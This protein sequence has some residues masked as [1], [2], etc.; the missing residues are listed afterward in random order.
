MEKFAAMSAPSADA[1]PDIGTTRQ[2]AR[3]WAVCFGLRTQSAS[4]AALA[5]H[6]APLDSASIAAAVRVCL[7]RTLGAD[8]QQHDAQRFRS[9]TRM[10]S[11]PSSIVI[12]RRPRT[13]VRPMT[14]S[15]PFAAAAVAATSAWLNLSRS[16]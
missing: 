16:H 4:R 12:V 13:L 8:A 5:A 2:T 9:A 15:F 7:P 11:K 6:N 1:F 10:P 14:L 3:N